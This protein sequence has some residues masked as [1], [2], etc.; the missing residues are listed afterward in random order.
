DLGDCEARGSAGTARVYAV[1]MIDANAKFNW[2]GGSEDNLTVN[3]RSDTL[4][5]LGI[6][7]SPMLVFPGD[8]DDQGGQI[9]GNKVHLLVGI[10][11]KR[12]WDDYFLPTY[13]EEVID[14]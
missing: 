3:D 8:L 9:L 5:M 11:K 7:P 13:W 12:D 6:P 1:D 14:D 10:E 2:N 4:N